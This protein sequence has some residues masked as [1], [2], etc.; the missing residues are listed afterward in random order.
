MSVIIHLADK[1]GMHDCVRLQW[2][3]CSRGLVRIRE[4]LLYIEQSTIFESWSKHVVICVLIPL[5]I[6][7]ANC[8]GV[9]DI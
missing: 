9:W 6:L 4:L 1:S 7:D 5:D 3:E 8:V 2:K